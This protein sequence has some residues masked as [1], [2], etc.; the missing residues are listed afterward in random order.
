LPVF[1]SQGA[2]GELPID[3]LPQI[4]ESPLDHRGGGEEARLA[5]GQHRGQGRKRPSR[6]AATRWRS[7]ATSRCWGSRFRLLN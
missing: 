2:A 5:R 7:R 1:A 3:Q 6:V 4:L